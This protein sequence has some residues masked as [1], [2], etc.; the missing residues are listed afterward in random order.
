MLGDSY[1]DLE[2]KVE[3]SKISEKV[4]FSIKNRVAGFFKNIVTDPDR[5][6]F[7]FCPVIVFACRWLEMF[8]L[9]TV[10]PPK[11]VRKLFY[12]NPLLD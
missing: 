9:N 6:V 11:V 8:D 7:R 4:S 5:P 2:V 10:C 1:P 3:E 12:P